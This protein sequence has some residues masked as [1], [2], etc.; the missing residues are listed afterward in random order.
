MRAAQI[1]LEIAR[2][3]I[4]LAQRRLENANEL[5]RLGSRDS[6]NVVE[7]L[8]DLTRAQNDFDDARARLQIAILQ[9]L[10]DTGTLRVDPSAGS[11]GHVLNRASR[12]SKDAARVNGTPAG[13]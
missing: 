11:V 8:N 6:R 12:D 5:L 7:A 13:G 9:F 3:S 10:R 1:S 4:E 2:G